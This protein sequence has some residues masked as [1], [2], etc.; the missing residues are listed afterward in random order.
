MSFKTQR[1]E[2]SQ[3]SESNLVIDG[4]E[5]DEAVKVI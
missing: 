2:Q 1:K 3:R 5:S 4:Q